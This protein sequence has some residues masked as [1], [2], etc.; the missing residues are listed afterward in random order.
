MPILSARV[1]LHK[2]YTAAQLTERRAA[3]TVALCRIYCDVI[4]LWR[5][6]AVKRCK[7]HRRC[8]G[9]PWPCLQRGRAGV[10]RGLYPK[11]LV[12]V[13][14][15]GSAKLPPIN[16]LESDMRRDPPGWLR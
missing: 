5:G 16:N 8:C 13:R 6:C 1:N 9:E 15:G 3:A 10:P 14:A 4:G 2:R 11:I 7:R 12:E